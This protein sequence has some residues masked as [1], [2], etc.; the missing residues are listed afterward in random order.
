MQLRAFHEGGQVNIEICDDGAGLHPEKLKAKAREKNL[1]TQEQAERMPDHEAGQLIFLP[2][3][4]TAE[5]VSNVSGRGVGMDVVK[6][7]IEKI[8]GMIDIQSQVGLGTTIK[9]KIPLTL[10]IIPAL[11]ITNDGNRFAIPQVNLLE[12]LRLDG[13]QD[14]NG[15]EWIQGAPVYRLRGRLLPL[16]YLSQLLKTGQ[17]PAVSAEAVNIVV[18]RADDRQFGLVVVKVITSIAEQTN[19][20]ALNA[21]IEAARAGEAVKGFAVVANEVK[22]LAKETA[23]ATEDISQKIETIQTDT[24]GAVD[25]IKQISDV[26]DQINDISSTIASAV[27]EQTATAN[28]MGRN[29][30]EAARGSEEIT[31]NITAVASAAQSTTV[32]ATNTQQAAGELSRMAADLQQLVSR[33]TF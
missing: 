29:V 5:K 11:T 26:I 10:A 28:E 24:R 13:N 7:N 16:V 33:F 4:S 12:L 3:F 31:S 19:P 17:E 21:T 20:L 30:A 6:T 8:G 15:I 1:I 27:E 18:L 23:K 25:A 14:H 9:I 2:G 32:G 22:E